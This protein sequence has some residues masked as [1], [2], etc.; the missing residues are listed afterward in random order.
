MTSRPTRFAGWALRIAIFLVL[1]G[2]IAVFQLDRA[3]RDRI[4]LLAWVPPGIGGFADANVARPL[5]L[6][7]PDMAVDRARATLRHRPVDAGNLAA[8]AIASV[9]AGD[10]AIAGQ[11]LSLAAQ[12]GWRDTYT[13]VM[14]IG[15]A[16]AAERWEVAAQRV[17]A[18]AR[19]RREDEAINGTLSLLLQND[20]GQRELATRMSTSIP[21]V[22]AV[23]KFL[24]NYPEFGPEVAQSFVYAQQEGEFSCGQLA[25]VARLLL[26]NDMS[27]AVD[28]LWPQR[29]AAAQR[30]GSGFR[31]VDTKLDPF[32]WHFPSVAGVSVRE[33]EA[34]GTLTARNRDPLRRQFAY[35]YI[36]LA[37]GE[38]TVTLRR[39]DSS[40]A[41]R[42][43]GTQS[44]QIS[45]AIRCVRQGERA[46]ALYNGSYDGA[47]RFIVPE[48][49]A[50]QNLSLSM[51]KGQVTDLSI[52]VN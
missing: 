6:V 3:S 5:A 37:P 38:H 16:L 24:Q 10:E 29:C 18:L 13:Q 33:G 11:A 17:D 9:E 34:A 26:A 12:R 20:G 22:D 2:I 50:T 49:C 15:S 35:R 48:D 8:F 27:A 23:S 44:A 47:V 42:R 46:G 36:T 4:S 19:L 7:R 1:A 52:S 45:V 31:F 40:A 25:R 30:E 51:G 28:G 39:A 14:V 21:L 41:S 43:P 32:A